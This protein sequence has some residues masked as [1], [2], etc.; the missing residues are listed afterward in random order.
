MKKQKNKTAHVHH[1]WDQNELIVQKI[2]WDCPFDMQSIGAKQE[3]SK[4]LLKVPTRE[5]TPHPL[6]TGSF[7][8]ILRWVLLYIN[9]KVFSR[10]ILASHKILS[11]LKVQFTIYKNIFQTI[12]KSKINAALRNIEMRNSPSE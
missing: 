11:L 7:S 4:N 5:P 12:L 1:W 2:S 6:F 3:R 8:R 10:P 9:L